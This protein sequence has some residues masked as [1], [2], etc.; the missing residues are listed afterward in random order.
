MAVKST[1]Y[2]WKVIHDPTRSEDDPGAFYRGCFR[3]IDIS[4]TEGWP[5]G[6][7]FQNILTRQ[8]LIIQ[9]GEI[10]ELEQPTAH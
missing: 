5:E 7:I 3:H 8:T 9:D 10:R 6:I 1:S 4:C 2:I